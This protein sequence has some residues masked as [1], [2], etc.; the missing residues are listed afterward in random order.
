MNHMHPILVHIG[1][2]L[3]LTF[4]VWLACYLSDIHLTML[5]AAL[6]GFVGGIVEWKFKVWMVRQLEVVREE[7]L[8]NFR[9]IRNKIEESR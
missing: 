6:L 9:F 4:L 8:S 3:F 5:S 7:S 1:K 2:Y